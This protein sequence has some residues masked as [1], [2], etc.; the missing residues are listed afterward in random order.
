MRFAQARPDQPFIRAQLAIIGVGP[1][2]SFNSKDL[3]IVE[4]AIVFLGLAE[5]K[6]NLDEARKAL[7]MPINGDAPDPEG[8]PSGFN[9]A[10]LAKMR[11][12]TPDRIWLRP[13]VL[14][15]PKRPDEFRPAP[16]N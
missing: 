5:G 15:S 1:G 12:P 9:Q 2:K 3:P 13:G 7:G 4:K 14:G 8:W 6:R 11:I 10:Q 16:M